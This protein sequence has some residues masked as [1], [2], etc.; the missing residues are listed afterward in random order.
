M[1]DT[2]P[3][4]PKQVIVIGTSAGGLSALKK[5]LSQLQ[6]NFPLPVLVVQH[7][8]A[9]ATGNVML[10]VLHKNTKLKCL[11]AKTGEPL[12]PGH[13]YLAPSDHHLMID[14]ELKIKVTKG[15]HENRS[16]PA[17]NPLFRSGPVLKIGRA[18]V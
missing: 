18:H 12:L 8:A 11:H 1:S 15:A 2:T 5:L 7:I 16:R 13:I 17:I 4:N 10:D 6:D 9:D 14:E 3:I